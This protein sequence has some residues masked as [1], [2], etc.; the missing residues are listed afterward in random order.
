MTTKKKAVLISLIVV[1]FV[2]AALVTVYFI[3]ADAK[4]K[5]EM[6]R[7]EKVVAS[8]ADSGTIHEG[9]TIDG[10]DVGGMTAEEATAALEAREAEILSAVSIDATYEGQTFTFDENYVQLDYDP[11]A[12][13]EEAMAV[14]RSG[15]YD[16]LVNELGQIENEGL[17]FEVDYTLTASGA[18]QFAQEVAA[19]IDQEAV[20]AEILIN[21]EDKT[22]FTI[23]QSQTGLTLNQG[24][25]TTQLEQRVAAGAS[26]AIELSVDTV[27]PMVSTEYLEENMVLRASAET[28]FASGSYDRDTRVFNI[29]MAADFVSG[30]VVLPGEEFSTNEVMGDRTYDLGWQPAPGYEGGKTVD[31]AGGGVCQVSSTM[32]N[33]VV[34]ADL[35]I[36]HRQNHSMP[37]GYVSKGLDATISTGTIDFIWKN[38]LEEPVLVIAYTTSDKDMVVEIYGPTLANGEYDQIKLTSEYTGSITPGEM[39]YEVD[40]SKPVGYES[41]EVE[42][43]TGSTYQSYKHYY[44]DGELVKTEKLDTSTYRAY[45]GLTIVGPEG[46][47][48]ETDDGSEGG[49]GGEDVPDSGDLDFQPVS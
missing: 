31:S 13:I 2:A 34:K 24:A 37:V 46:D 40:E 38:N 15:D 26:N 48:S 30:T 25:L 9:I 23:S 44:L 17:D 5:A 1:A 47:D 19:Q 18:A 7:Q 3:D 27:T 20:E 14:A 32:Y 39:V 22:T 10:V 6:E 41:V 49:D 21:E 12:A 36:I 28:S 8:I 35:E 4:N 29:N 43:R 16:T 33:A 42:R 11:T 45:A